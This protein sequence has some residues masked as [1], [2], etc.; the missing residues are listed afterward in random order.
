MVIILVIGLETET[1]LKEEN[2][3]KVLNTYFHDTM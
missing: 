1:L 3:S 2:E